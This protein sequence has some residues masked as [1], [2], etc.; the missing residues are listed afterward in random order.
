MKL[1]EVLVTLEA[2]LPVY[3]VPVLLSLYNNIFSATQG[4]TI[5]VPGLLGN[6]RAKVVR[7][8]FQGQLRRIGFSWQRR[9]GRVM[10]AL[11]MLNSHSM[12]LDTTC[13]HKMLKKGHDFTS[14]LS[15]VQQL[16]SSIRVS[17]SCFQT[18]FKYTVFGV[19]VCIHIIVQEKQ[20]QY[21][22]NT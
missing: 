14:A 12:I 20:K 19:S 10:L 22:P 17:G 16:C 5:W 4:P 6:A 18:V 1:G 2:Q 8:R 13:E 9:K 15:D 7:I 21:M 11:T 3:W